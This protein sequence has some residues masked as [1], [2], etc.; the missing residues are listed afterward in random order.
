[1]PQRPQFKKYLTVPYGTPRWVAE[2]AARN[3]EESQSSVKS[4]SYDPRDL[5]IHVRLNWEVTKSFVDSMQSQ[6]DGDCKL[7]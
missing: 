7:H 6:V 5:K 2:R 4:A 1:M 3:V